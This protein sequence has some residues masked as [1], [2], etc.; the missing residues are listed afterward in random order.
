MCAAENLLGYCPAV[1]QY[2]SNCIV[3]WWAGR[4]ILLGCNTPRC[5]VDERRLGWLG[6][7][8][9]SWVYRDMGTREQ[10]ALGHNALAVS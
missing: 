9:Y 7:S 5:I 10:E 4:L 1:S 2:S 6:M 8:R 3:T